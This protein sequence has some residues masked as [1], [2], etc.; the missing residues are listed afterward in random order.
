MDGHRSF[1]VSM[2]PV[3]ER[4]RNS[5]TTYRTETDTCVRCGYNVVRYPPF[6]LLCP[7][8]CGYTYVQV[9]DACVIHGMCRIWLVIREFKKKTTKSFENANNKP[10]T[11]EMN[12]RATLVTVC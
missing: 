8:D 6:W 11:L 10:I 2:V 4:S 1:A 12:K 7:S 5:E 9:H 3:V